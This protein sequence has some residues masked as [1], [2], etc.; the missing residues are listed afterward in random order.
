[1]GGRGRGEKS[2]LGVGSNR[3]PPLCRSCLEEVPVTGKEVSKLTLSRHKKPTSHRKL[4][5]RCTCSRYPSGHSF[6]SRGAHIHQSAIVNM[7]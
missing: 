4:N 2:V 3:P 1:M 5:I 6:R 7:R